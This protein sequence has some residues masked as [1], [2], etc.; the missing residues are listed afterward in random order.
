MNGVR[1][2]AVLMFLAAYLAGCSDANAPTAVTAVVAPHFTGYEGLE[3]GD[4][5]AGGELRLYVGD[6]V[7]LET[8]LDD[9]GAVLIAP[10][11]RRYDLQ[12]SLDSL[13]P[14]CFWGEAIFAVTFPSTPLV[15]E[16]AYICAGQ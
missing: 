1:I 6:T 3:P 7:V 14:G 8:V 16:V 11:P 12:V 9:T 4:P 13:E 10:E 5:V 15:V 2:G